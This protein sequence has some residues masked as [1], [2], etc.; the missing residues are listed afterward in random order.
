MSP[1]I[2]LHV[3]NPPSADECGCPSH[4]MI[5]PISD[6]WGHYLC[7]IMGKQTPFHSCYAYP[8]AT[9]FF[10]TTEPVCCSLIGAHTREPI[11]TCFISL[12]RL[13]FLPIVLLGFLLAQDGKE[14]ACSAG[15]LSNF[16]IERS[17]REGHTPLQYYG[18]C[19][20]INLR[21]KWV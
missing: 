3:K 13:L 18:I 8:D 21:E 16:V 7:L 12:R 17:S 4:N 15:N 10:Q 5:I 14:T 11:Q 1:F 2:P 19:R 6:C 9:P 20:Y